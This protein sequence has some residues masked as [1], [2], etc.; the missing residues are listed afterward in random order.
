MLILLNIEV[1]VV[2]PAK[3]NSIVQ[4]KETVEDC[5]F[6]RTSSHGCVTEW[7]KFAMIGFETL[8]GFVG[9]LL[10]HNYHKAAH[11]KSCISLL[12]VV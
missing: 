2:I 4:S 12:S 10:Q 6:V 11:E 5:A 3:G 1:I 8:P 9:T 7:H